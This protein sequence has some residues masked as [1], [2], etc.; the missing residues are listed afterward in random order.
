MS[1]SGSQDIPN[2]M[3]QDEEAFRRQLH[4]Q[5]L[6]RQHQQHQHQ[7]QQP[8]PNPH[9]HVPSPPSNESHLQDLHNANSLYMG[10]P[11]LTPQQ[12]H[13]QQHQ[14]VSNG[15]STTPGAEHMYSMLPMG[16]GSYLKV[17]HNQDDTMKFQNYELFSSN[18]FIQIPQQLNA[19][20]LGTNSHGLHTHQQQT[21]QPSMYPSQQPQQSQQLFFDLGTSPSNIQQQ[22]TPAAPAAA[23]HQND[24]TNNVL[25]NQLAENWVPNIS[26]TYSP[27]G[28]PQQHHPS[29]QMRQHCD[30]A[31]EQFQHSL[32]HGAPLSLPQIPNT[33]IDN[34]I[35]PLHS[36]ALTQQQQPQLMS[37]NSMVD[38]LP[39]TVD[40]QQQPQSSGTNGSFL[41]MQHEEYAQKATPTPK[42][43]RMVAEVKPMRKTYA[44]VVSKNV[45][46]KKDEGSVLSSVGA[47]TGNPIPVVEP[48]VGGAKSNASTKTSKEN[49]G[50]QQHSSQ[51]QGNSF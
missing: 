11:Q 6:H 32:M 24:N 39:T 31:A 16:N 2:M 19:A 33:I 44:D 1:Q 41:Q 48:L 49:K 12:Q 23:P 43:P 10:G 29:V 47:S 17:Y 35:S 21:Q 5:Q 36:L 26:G 27:F 38:P 22:S 8:P 28:E 4:M 9:F 40:P 25:I 15:G 37:I 20:Q 7:A 51:A 34:T 13:Q 3:W 46:T 30:I 50:K 42:K 18:S 45:L 14:Q